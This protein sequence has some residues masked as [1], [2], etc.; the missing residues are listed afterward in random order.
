MSAASPH[1]TRLLEATLDESLIDKLSERLIDDKAYDADKLDERLWHE[2]GNRPT[3]GVRR[4][5]PSV[6]AA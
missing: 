6:R 1:E 4:V 5:H 3:G 2:R